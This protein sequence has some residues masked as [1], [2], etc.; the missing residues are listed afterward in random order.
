[1]EEAKLRL[2]GRPEGT[3]WFKSTKDFRTGLKESLATQITRP[4][5]LHMLKLL[6]DHRLCQLK[7]QEP[8]TQSHTK[9]LRVWLHRAKLRDYDEALRR[10][11]K[12]SKKRK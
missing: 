6:D 5:Q 12:P 11:W 3:G 7:P 1:M 2:G 9:L 8:R 4:T 10:Y